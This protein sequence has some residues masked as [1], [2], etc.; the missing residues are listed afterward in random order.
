MDATKG[1]GQKQKL[2]NFKN[3]SHEPKHVTNCHMGTQQMKL[4]E[5]I[6]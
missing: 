4:N 2:T 1:L 6:H 5:T 3:L